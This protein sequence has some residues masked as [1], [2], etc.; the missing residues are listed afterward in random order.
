V[1]DGRAV[2]E[3]DA[4]P[5]VPLGFGGREDTVARTS[6]EPGDRIVMFSD[7]VVE[8]RSPDG[9]FFGT[10]RLVDLLTRAASLG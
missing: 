7:G 9:V 4:V 3:L 6:L 8:A 5:G 1:R 10:D 2:G